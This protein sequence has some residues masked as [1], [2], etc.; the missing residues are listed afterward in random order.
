[1]VNQYGKFRRTGALL[2]A[3][4]SIYSGRLVPKC[5]SGALLLLSLS[6]IESEPK[7]QFVGAMKAGCLRLV[8]LA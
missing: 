2:L 4:D 8:A 5:L 6:K 7:L 1:M 3:I